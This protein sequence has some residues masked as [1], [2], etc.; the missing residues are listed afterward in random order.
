MKTHNLYLILLLIAAVLL[1]PACDTATVAPD[2]HEHEALGDARLFAAKD[3]HDVVELIASIPAGDIAGVDADGNPIPCTVE[4]CALLPGTLFPP[5]EGSRSWLKRSP[6]RLKIKVETTGLP[7]GAYTS[8]WVIFDNPEGCVEGPGQCSP[9]DYFSIAAENT[10]Y[11]A[12]GFVVGADGRAEIK[13]STRVGDDLGEPGQ[14]W[15]FGDGLSNP[16]GAEVFF[17]LLYH[18]PA[19]SDPDVLELQTTTLNGGCLDGANAVDYGDFGIGCFD[20]QIAIHR[21]GG[22]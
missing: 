6:H 15:I 2:A 22:G 20:P 13:A 3:N 4:T 5:T 8:W 19:S 17:D 16:M 1:L 9:A 18:G 10:V 7:P 11:F 12:A 21:A 14:Q